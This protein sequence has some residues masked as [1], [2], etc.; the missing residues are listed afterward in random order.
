[1]GNDIVNLARSLHIDASV[2]GFVEDAACNE[3]RLESNH[4]TFIYR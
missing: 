1:M 2:A 3:V 4:G